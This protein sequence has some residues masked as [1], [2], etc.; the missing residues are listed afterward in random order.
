MSCRP[1]A[2]AARVAPARAGLRVGAGEGLRTIVLST[3]RDVRW[4]DSPT[5]SAGLAS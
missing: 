2:A 4:N 1:T 3:F 5:E